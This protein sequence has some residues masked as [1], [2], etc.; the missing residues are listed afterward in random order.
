MSSVNPRAVLAGIGAAIV[1]FALLRAGSL[2]PRVAGMTALAGGAAVAALADVA[3]GGRAR[4]RLD[5][6][7][8][9]GRIAVAVTCPLAV[10]VSRLGPAWD[11]ALLGGIAFAAG[12]GTAWV[13]VR[14]RR[15][16]RRDTT[17][18]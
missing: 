3:L 7:A 10:V 9:F 6:R 8:L 15:G 14:A 18:G 1:L 12:L 11:P 2:V 4:T 17:A 13:A 5:D 16:G